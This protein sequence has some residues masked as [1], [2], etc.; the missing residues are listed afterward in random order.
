L[1]PVPITIAIVVALIADLDAPSSG[2]IRLNERAIQRLK[3][4]LRRNRPDDTQA[5]LS[6]PAGTLMKADPNIK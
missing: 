3:T 2:L 1:V 6:C 5:L 4:E